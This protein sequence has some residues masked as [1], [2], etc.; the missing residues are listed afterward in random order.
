M[1]SRGFGPRG[2]FHVLEARLPNELSAL[3]PEHIA[4]VGRAAVR[5]RFLLTKSEGGMD[6]V[7]AIQLLNDLDEAGMTDVVADLAKAEGAHDDEDELDKAMDGLSE[8]EQ[9]RLKAARKIMGPAMAKRFLKAHTE[10]DGDEEDEEPDGDEPQLKRR[11]GESLAAY[12]KRKKAAMR[13]AKDTSQHEN[14]NPEFEDTPAKFSKSEDG[15]Y[16]LTAIPEAQRPAVLAILTKADEDRERLEK[17]ETRLATMIEKEDRQ[18]YLRKAAGMTHLPGVKPEDFAE[19][20]RD[21]GKNMKPEH[22]TKLEATLTKADTLLSKSALFGE[23]GVASAAESDADPEAEIVA[24]AVEVQKSEK[25]LSPEAA[26][27]RV[28]KGDPALA[29]RV[30]EAHDRKIAKRGS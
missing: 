25:G 4:M 14:G 16:D 23:L 5:R 27:A 12:T 20:L 18:V 3:E 7:Q 19:V 17:A 28:L 6:D 15:A 8:A 1:S 26:R 9:K 2:L 21:A 13:K 10:P 11:K 24:K 30:I 22:F 29:R